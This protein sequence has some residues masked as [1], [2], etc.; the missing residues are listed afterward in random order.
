MQCQRSHVVIFWPKPYHNVFIPVNGSRFRGWKHNFL[1]KLVR[2]CT[3]YDVIAPWLD[4][5][6]SIFLL[7]LRK[8]CPISYAKKN[9]TIRLAIREPFQKN[10]WGLH[11]SPRHGWRL[12]HVWLEYFHNTTDG[13]GGDDDWP[14][15]SSTDMCQDPNHLFLF[16]SRSWLIQEKYIIYFCSRP[17]HVWPNSLPCLVKISFFHFIQNFVPIQDSVRIVKP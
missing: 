15:T 17:F 1:E 10:S 14:Q 9:S 7:K 2:G 12:A 11:P 4:L 8:G 5:T 3:S 13:G 6:R 16:Y